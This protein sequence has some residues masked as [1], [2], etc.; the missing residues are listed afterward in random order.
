MTSDDT[1]EE[2][3]PPHDNYVNF[4]IA[5]TVLEANARKEAQ[6]QGE[7]KLQV[8]LKMMVVDLWL[9]VCSGDGLPLLPVVNGLDHDR[10]S[11]RNSMTFSE[12]DDEE[13]D[14]P[15]E[16]GLLFQAALSLQ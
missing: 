6:A 9:V 4:D 15:K 14:Y 8:H 5:Q 3:K 13:E 10:P 11:E 7:F 1:A 2:D 16:V 12:L